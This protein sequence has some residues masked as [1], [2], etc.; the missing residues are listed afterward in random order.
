MEPMEAQP[1]RSRFEDRQ[2]AKQ[3][4]EQLKP[5]RNQRPIM[6]LMFGFGVCFPLEIARFRFPTLLPRLPCVQKEL[7]SEGEH[8]AAAER[9]A[10]L[11]LEYSRWAVLD[12][13]RQEKHRRHCRRLQIQ[14]AADSEPQIETDS[15][16]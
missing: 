10:A 16:C 13:P 9:I 12:S 5:T 7:A 4:T 8:Q 11:A 6:F 14:M 2:N 15:P 1:G 3:G